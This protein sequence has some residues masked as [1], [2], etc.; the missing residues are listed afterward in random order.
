MRH[1]EGKHTIVDPE[2]VQSLGF[3]S[4]AGF[5]A[6]LLV[7][8]QRVRD[9]CIENRCGNYYAH[10]MCPPYSGTL[11]QIKTQLRAY[12]RG[13]VLQ[14]SRPLDVEHDKEGLKR[15]KR[16]FHEMLLQLETCLREKG[17]KQ[18]WALTAGNCG[19]CEPCYAI[20]GEP[21][22]YPEKARTS[23]VALGIDVISLLDR[24]GLDSGFHPD[25]ITWTGCMLF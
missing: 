13:I 24:L 22:P 4:H 1:K 15:T 10:Y 12:E 17:T 16:E 11:E 25:R 8:E 20:K 14:Y 21:C 9:L 19:L 5:D 23:L 7:P 18:L 3:T 2:C 6:G